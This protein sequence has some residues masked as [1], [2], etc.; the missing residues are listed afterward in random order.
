LLDD[1]IVG[2]LGAAVDGFFNSLL[3]GVRQRAATGPE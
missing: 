1:S 3:T 2:Y